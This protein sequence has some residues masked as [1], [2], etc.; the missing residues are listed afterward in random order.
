[1]AERTGGERARVEA[2]A[3]DIPVNCHWLSSGSILI[4][5]TQEAVGNAR[6]LRR[7]DMKLVPPPLR[8]RKKY[9]LTPVHDAF[10][11]R[12]G[13]TACQLLVA[14]YAEI[15]NAGL[16]PVIAAPLNSYA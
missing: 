7:R 11:S 16:H 3:A 6:Y 13:S 2:D 5:G 8:W 14:M 12:D 9:R 10:F 1:M 15:L 4:I